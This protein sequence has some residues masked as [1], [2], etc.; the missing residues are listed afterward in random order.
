MGPSEALRAP[1]SLEQALS[2]PLVAL[3]WAHLPHFSRLHGEMGETSVAAR[4]QAAGG[5]NT[6]VNFYR[7]L[8]ATLPKRFAVLQSFSPCRLNSWTA[9]AWALFTKHP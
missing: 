3:E 6:G 9:I 4:R 1:P 8:A 7:L 5:R 2:A